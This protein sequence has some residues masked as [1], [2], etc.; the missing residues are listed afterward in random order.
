MENEEYFA[1]DSRGYR[2]ECSKERF[3]YL[4]SKHEESED[5]IKEKHIRA[6]IENP[7]HGIIYS[8][9]TI[10]NRC[11]YYKRVRGFPTEIKVVVDFSQDNIGEINTFYLCSN[12]PS[13]EEIIWPNIN[14]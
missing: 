5:L 9:N 10:P 3:I 6:A 13:G 8:D 7:S 14:H 2:V 11:V 4:L 1:R 12:R